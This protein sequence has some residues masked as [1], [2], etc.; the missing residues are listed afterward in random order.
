[1]G[2]QCGPIAFPPAGQS[3]LPCCLWP[4][5][6]EHT[7][8]AQVSG[9]GHLG[10]GDEE[11]ICLAP[12]LREAELSFG[13]APWVV[14]LYLSGLMKPQ[15]HSVPTTL[16]HVA[17]GV[18]SA[19]LPTAAGHASALLQGWAPAGLPA[20]S[21]GLTGLS[22]QAVSNILSLEHFWLA[23]PSLPSPPPPFLTAPEPFH[24]L[25]QPKHPP[26]ADRPGVPCQMSVLL[27]TK[28]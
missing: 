7:A 10:R 26:Q 12:G 13:P 25:V 24:W 18:Q 27:K 23:C 15:R 6:L 9:Q 21:V 14:S 28:P 5:L 17:L 3:C 20:Q 22:C 2:G 19:S 1:M 16:V 8:W 4:W 11:N